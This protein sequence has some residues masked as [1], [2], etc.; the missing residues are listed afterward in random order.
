[1]ASERIL[2]QVDRLLDEAEESVSRLDWSVVRERARAVL[3]L[4]PGNT[5]AVAYL[6]AAERELGDSEGALANRPL[7]RMTSHPEPDKKDPASFANGRY[8]VQKF[9]GQGGKK[10]VYLAQD[11]LFDREAAFALI[12]A[13]GPYSRRGLN[14]IFVSHVHKDSSLAI[15]LA[16]ALEAKG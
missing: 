12:K 7:A 5:D 14:R 4:E 2:R 15:A 8:E 13:G 11:T 3:G 10:R 1:M 6:E 16:D 9:L